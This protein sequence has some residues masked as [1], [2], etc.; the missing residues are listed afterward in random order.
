MCEGQ[1]SRPANILEIVAINQGQSPLTMGEPEAPALSPAEF[2]ALSEGGHAVVDTRAPADFGGGHIPGAYSIKLTS[3]EFEQRVGWVVPLETP[4]ILVTETEDEVRSAL[5]KLA[6]VGLDRRVEGFLAGGMD[7]WAGAGMPEET[8]PQITVT[9]L[10]ELLLADDG[11][12]VLDVRE[13]EEWDAGHVEGAESMSFKV[14]EKR[15]D[16]L[17]IGADDDVA[18]MCAAGVRSSTASSILLRN[19]YRRVRNITGGFTAWSAAE[20]PVVTD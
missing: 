16:E 9:E 20:L 2:T 15:L 14:L 12:R 4:I 5:H 13:P 19:G 7:A 11:M 17:S 8:L 3:P 18:V 1:P 6:F 10:Q